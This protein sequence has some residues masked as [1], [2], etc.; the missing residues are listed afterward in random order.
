MRIMAALLLCAD[1]KKPDSDGAD[2]RHTRSAG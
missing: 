2:A 1:E